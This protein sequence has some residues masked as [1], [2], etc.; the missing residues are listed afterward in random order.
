[1]SDTPLENV[2]RGS[3]IREHRLYEA[4][5][6]LRDYGFGLEELPFNQDGHLPQDVDPK[7]AWA[8]NN[9]IAHPLEINR[10]D[11]HE[12]LHI[13]GIGPKSVKAILAARSKN[14]ITHDEELIRHRS[15]SQTRSSLYFDKW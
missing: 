4:S 9:L 8:R 1:M 6:L 14:K 10:M 2:P 15:K 12:L 5:F 11:S 3:P 13:P 7:F